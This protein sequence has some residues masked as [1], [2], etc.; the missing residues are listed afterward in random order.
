MTGFA[1]SP[2]GK[3]LA[4]GCGDSVVFWETVGPTLAGQRLKLADA[5]IKSVAFSP[6]GK[7]VAAGY[8]RDHSGGV[9]IWEIQRR[10][11]LAEEPM[12]SAGISRAS[13]LA[14]TAQPSPSQITRATAA[15]WCSGTRAG[16]A[17][18]ADMPLEVCTGFVTSVAISPDSST[19]A[20]GYGQMVGG[21]GVVLWDAR[22]CHRRVDK[23]LQ[24]AREG[25]VFSVAFSPD[26][27]TVAGGY[28]AFPL[29]NGV[30]LWDAQRRTQL[31]HAP[32]DLPESWLSDLAFSPDGKALAVGYGADRRSCGVVLWN[33]QTLTPIADKALAFTEG[34]VTEL[35][36]SPDGSIIAASF[37]PQYGVLS[38]GGEVLWNARTGN[39]LTD[40]PL[41][42]AEGSADSIAFSP[43][44]QTLAAGCDGGVLL[45]DTRLRGRLGE[46]P[47]F[48]CKEFATNLAFSP[49]GRTL[50]VGYTD[51]VGLAPFGDVALIDVDLESWKNRA[52]KIANRNLT[53]DEWH[54]F[55]PDTPY[56]ATFNNLSAPPEER[57]SNTTRIE[58]DAKPPRN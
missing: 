39:R 4:A 45:W 58:I 33:A 47:L 55:F 51:L 3:T 41:E 46:N 2:D 6:D 44:G 53:R 14:P 16:D 21:G 22:Q 50:A 42:V 56:H 35:A 7:T 25:N 20:A 9:L 43:D 17:R 24:A 26:G 5:H 15:G 1:F 23:P 34:N 36:F 32:L 8:R 12:H 40:K 18:L 52:R 37:Q 54:Q 57:V 29:V 28:R 38:V 31:A 48:V 11:R 19:V 30:M 13:P 27:K 49:D 10:S